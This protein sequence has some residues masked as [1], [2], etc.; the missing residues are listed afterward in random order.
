MNRTKF[1]YKRAGFDENSV[2][3]YIAKYLKHE[4]V[5][6]FGWGSLDPKLILN[7]VPSPELN[8]SI[9]GIYNEPRGQAGV[10]EEVAEF[11][12]QK[13]GKKITPEQIM[14][15]NGA[16]NA[17]FILAHYFTHIKGVKE[18]IV[19]NP[20]YDTALNIFG[21][22]GLHLRGV[23]PLCTD[24]PNI[25]QSFAYLLLKNHNPTGISIPTTEKDK[26]ISQLASGNNYVIEDDAY[27]LLSKN[28]KI[29]LNLSP[30]Y[31]YVGSFSKY[32]FPGLRLGYVVANPELINSLKIIQKYYN[33]HPNIISQL[34]LSEY[35]KQGLIDSEISHKTDLITRKRHEFEKHVSP[36]V[37]A[38]VEPSSSGF[39]F[40]IHL[41]QKYSA[42]DVFKEL[43]TQGVI[44]VPGDIY[45][46]G[47]SYPALRVSI[48][49]I[50]IDDIKDGCQLI[51]QVLEK[52]V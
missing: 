2:S 16:T 38:S 46:S 43:L 26:I 25:R 19:Q 3:D 17:L 30:Y 52:Y 20:T 11:L 36:K 50:D 9:I 7:E 23:S 41:N 28:S 6:N 40:W 44:T 10:I 21:S 1:I 4:R 49:Q 29:E 5:F 37:L 42:I 27:G 34:T 32:I 33:S 45:F 39:Y 13:S 12:K 51:N 48:S 35:F 22:Q 14:I 15:T 47:N 24:L 18:A 8:N 31:I